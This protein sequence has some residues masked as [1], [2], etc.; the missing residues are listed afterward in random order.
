MNTEIRSL[1]EIAQEIKSY[2]ERIRENEGYTMDDMANYLEINSLT[3]RNAI[4]KNVWSDLI[5][6]IL[7]LKGVIPPELCYEY[8]KSLEKEKIKRRKE[9]RITH[10]PYED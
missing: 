4:Y 3:F 1:D 10:D 7:K 8:R 6:L 2:L 5:V 9:R